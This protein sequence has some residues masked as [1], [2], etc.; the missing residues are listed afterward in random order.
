MDKFEASNGAVLAIYSQPGVKAIR[1]RAADYVVYL[2][3]VQV[4]A[5]REFFRAERKPWEYAKDGEVW[6]LT[7]NGDTG[8]FIA[9]D[10]ALMGLVY[11]ASNGSRIQSNDDQITAGERIWPKGEPS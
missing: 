9:Y 7:V 8:P 4:D 10:D 11:T 1:V 6:L 3:G 5:L 2:S